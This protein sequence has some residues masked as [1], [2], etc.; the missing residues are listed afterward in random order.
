MNIAERLADF[1]VNADPD[2]RLTS[3]IRRAVADCFG[4]ILVGA[5]SEVA[6][7]LSAAL[8]PNSKGDSTLYGQN[9]SSNP[10]VAALI[11]SAAGHAYDLDDWEEPG[12]THPSVV[13]VPACLAVADMKQVSGADLLTA[14]AIGFEVIVRLGEAITLDHYKRGYHSTATLGAIGSTAAV[15]RIIGLDRKNNI[16]CFVSRCLSGLRLY[17]TIWL[18]R[19]GNSSRFGCSCGT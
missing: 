16:T 12:N 2:P 3:V 6:K 10:S 18:Q 8:V 15:S 7:R 5:D 19:E 4:C 9:N 11:N 1:V 13:I 14:Y 17:L